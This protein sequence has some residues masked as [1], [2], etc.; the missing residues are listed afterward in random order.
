MSDVNK[1]IQLYSANSYAYRIR[2]LIYI[3]KKDLDKACADL[4]TAIDKGF[5]AIYG[6]EVIELQKKYCGKWGLS[7]SRWK[8]DLVPRLT[9]ITCPTWGCKW[10]TPAH[11]IQAFVVTLALVPW[12][13]LGL[14][15]KAKTRRDTSR[16]KGNIKVRAE[17]ERGR[18]QRACLYRV[19]T[20]KDNKCGAKL[21]YYTWNTPNITVSI[22]VEPTVKKST[23]K[24]LIFCILHL[25][26]F[27]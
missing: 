8:A 25:L 21:L 9:L 11:A 16:S 4:Q 13:Q 3:E 6:N 14:A 22:P 1:S 24:W 23:I 26:Y 15:E 2:A 10:R 7:H 5:T 12:L 19:S 27:Y 17:K 20:T 18:W